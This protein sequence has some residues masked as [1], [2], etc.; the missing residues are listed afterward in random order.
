M[1]E[2][3]LD[4]PLARELG[5]EGDGLAVIGDLEEPV[6][7]VVV[8]GAG[9]DERRVVRVQGVDVLVETDLD[10]ASG[11]G[12]LGEGLP[13][14]SSGPAAEQAEGRPPRGFQHCPPGGLA[15]P[16]QAVDNLESILATHGSPPPFR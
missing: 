12:L 13:G 7:D 16:E 11:L 2:V 6:V 10:S 3:A 9:G 14:P 5:L 15:L 4:L 1:D 8:D